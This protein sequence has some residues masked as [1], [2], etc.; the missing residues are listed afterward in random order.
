[1]IVHHREISSNKD[2]NNHNNHNKGDISVRK[3]AARKST[4]MK[5]AK[6]KAVNGFH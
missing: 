4:L 5:I 3:A 1:M 2:S 6:A